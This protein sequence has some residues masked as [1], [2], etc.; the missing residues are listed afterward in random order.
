MSV[1]SNKNRM[2]SDIRMQ[3]DLRSSIDV[4]LSKGWEIVCRDPIM[5]R[6]GPAKIEVINGVI[7]HG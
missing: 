4:Y 3:L 6:R 2:I 7:N 5:L 1:Q